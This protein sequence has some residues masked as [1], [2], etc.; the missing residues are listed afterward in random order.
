MRF[1][2]TFSTRIIQTRWGFFYIFQLSCL[3]GLDNSL[4]SNWGRN[5]FGWEI[6][7]YNRLTII[8]SWRRGGYSRRYLGGSVRMF[9]QPL[10][11]SDQNTVPLDHLIFCNMMDQTSKARHTRPQCVRFWNRRDLGSRL[12]SSRTLAH[13]LRNPARARLMVVSWEGFKFIKEKSISKM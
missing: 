6:N 13:V 11:V 9:L 10:L 7:V 4:F 1:F 8:Y 12:C 3:V 5:Y 2:C